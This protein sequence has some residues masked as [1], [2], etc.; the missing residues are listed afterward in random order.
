MILVVPSNPGHSV[1]TILKFTGNVS[2]P[3]I[4]FKDRLYGFSFLHGL[5]SFSENKNE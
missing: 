1:I 4:I 3:K 5:G 2:V